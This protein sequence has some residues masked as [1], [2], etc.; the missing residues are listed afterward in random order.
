MH[1]SPEKAIHE[2]YLINQEQTES[3][4]DNSGNRGQIL[5]R[6][7]EVFTRVRNGD[8]HGRGHQHHA[9]DRS[10]PEYQQVRDGPQGAA[11]C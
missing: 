11:N 1:V 5:A 6:E 9:H 7:F 8:G 4:A 2:T 10:N 3:R